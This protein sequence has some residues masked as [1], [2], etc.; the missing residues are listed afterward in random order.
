MGKAAPKS[1]LRRALRRAHGL[2]A[3][4]RGRAASLRP[5]SEDYGFDRGKPI[6]RHYIEAFLAANEA[7]I[8]GT[9][10]EVADNMY[11]RRHGGGRVERQEILDLDPNSDRATITGDLTDAAVLPDGRFDCIIL[12]QTLHLIFDMAEAI[13]Q[14]HRALKPGGV[15]LLTAPGITPVDPGAWRDSWF[16]SLSEPALRRL[17]SGPFDGDRVS[18]RAYGNLHA[19][20]A[21]LHGAAVQEVSRR[22]LDRYD[23]SY[24]VIVAARAVR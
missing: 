11:S 12:T 22:K 13:E 18:T 5:L 24:P 2:L 17:L 9:V 20:T 16:W 15:L 4:N 8:A 3:M 23:P 6:D 14:L 19:A 21:F 1:R 10:L 7:D